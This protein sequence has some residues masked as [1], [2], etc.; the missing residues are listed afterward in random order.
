MLRLGCGGLLLVTLLAV[1]PAAAD[2]PL[3]CVGQ[4]DPTGIGFTTICAGQESFEANQLGNWSCD[5]LWDLRHNIL[6]T[7]GYCFKSERA[8]AAFDN[9]GCN[10]ETVAQA[11]PN[12]H[13]RHNIDLIA[14]LEKE[15]ACPAD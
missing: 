13:Q 7:L 14:S 8:K 2:E 15:K 1:R 4:P 6:Y 12:E 10:A 9:V 11:N 5:E 3:D